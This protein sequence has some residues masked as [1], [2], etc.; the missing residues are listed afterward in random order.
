MKSIFKYSFVVLAFL[1]SSCDGLPDV[2]ID[3]NNS[4]TARPQEV[5][6]AAQGYTGWVVDSRFNRL[7]FLWGQYWTWGPGVSLGNDARFVAEPDD[8]DNLWARAY[9]NALADLKFLAD[10]GSPAYAGVAKIMQ[11]HIYQNLVDHFGDIPFSEALKGEIADGSILNPTYDNAQ[12]IYTQLISLVDEGI[13]EVG[14]GA[15]DAIHGEDLVFGGDLQKWISYGNSLKLRILM[16]QSGTADVAAQVRELVAQNNFIDSQ[17][18]I[19]D[20]AFAGTAGDENPMYAGMEQGIGNFYIASNA[21]LNVLRNLNDP[22]IDALYAPAPNLGTIHGIDQ[23]SINLEGF[24]SVREDYSQGTAVTY[25]PAV[26]TI[27]MSNW[28]TWFLRAEAAARF[29]TADDDAVAFANAIRAHFDYLGVAGADDY[30]ASLGFGGSLNDKIAD[31]AVQKWISFNGLQ[32]DEGWVEARRLDTPDNRIFTGEGGI[33]QTPTSSALP[34][35][36]FPSSFLYPES[37]QSFN[38]NAP[39]QR[40]ITDRIFWDD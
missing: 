11:A 40:V 10:T 33:W 25:G 17:D 9:S 31:I 15:A 1:I 18:K 5:L 19:A 3:P 21:S 36:I 30:I 4:T 29:G 37:E 23:G 14:K 32:E 12:T 2:N 28:E 13:A 35:R 34:D 24:T 8:H 16:R 6:T 7:A 27:L 22:R 39:G 26:S 20:I 38:P